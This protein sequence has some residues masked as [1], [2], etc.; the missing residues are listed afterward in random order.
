[1][2]SIP[3]DYDQSLDTENSMFPEFENNSTSLFRPL[4]SPRLPTHPADAASDSTTAFIPA[5]L[6][7]EEGYFG[8]TETTKP[9]KKRV[10]KNRGRS[11]APPEDEAHFANP[12]AVA[13]M[14]NLPGEVVGFD[15]PEDAKPPSMPYGMP[16]AQQ[17]G[18]MRVLAAF[19]R[20]QTHDRSLHGNGPLNGR[21]NDSTAPN[22]SQGSNASYSSA[23]NAQASSR[24]HGA[25]PS[26]ST[27]FTPTGAVV[28]PLE[29]PPRYTTSGSTQSTFEPPPPYTRGRR[30]TRDN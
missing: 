20:S 19:T 27:T 28:S 12:N 5:G 1:M 24:F 22:S 18:I 21:G 4:R 2:A 25:G 15:E 3:R 11:T 26:M 9:R 16:S 8:D 6:E 7:E 23:G 14:A 10:R 30:L 29:A 17:L 13:F